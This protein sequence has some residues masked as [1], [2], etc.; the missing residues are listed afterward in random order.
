MENTSWNNKTNIKANIPVPD[1]TAT[2]C[3]N[4][5]GDSIITIIKVKL[6]IPIKDHNTMISIRYIYKMF[7]RV[8][9]KSKFFHTLT[10]VGKL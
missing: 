1:N 4:S 10:L 9:R 6:H 7:K 2:F 8:F 3:H 5:K